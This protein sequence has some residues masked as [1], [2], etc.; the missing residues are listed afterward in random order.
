MCTR[1]REQ[2]GVVEKAGA[3]EV[4]LRVREIGPDGSSPGRPAEE[5]NLIAWPKPEARHR[6]RACVQIHIDSQ[7]ACMLKREYTGRAARARPWELFEKSSYDAV[8]LDCHSNEVLRLDGSSMPSICTHSIRSRLS[9]SPFYFCSRF[10]C[11]TIQLS[12]I[13]ECM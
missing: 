5:S 8:Q 9:V 7:H 11:A 10:L 6:S 1:Q 4:T 13:K 2:Q 3:A 12:P